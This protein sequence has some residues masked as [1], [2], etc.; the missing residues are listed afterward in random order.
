MFET[1]YSYFLY[2]KSWAYILMFIILP[3]FVAYW[4]YILF[5]MKEKNPVKAIFTD[6]NDEHGAC[7]H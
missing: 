4:N 3:T 7:D 1:F 6:A 5:P 2:T